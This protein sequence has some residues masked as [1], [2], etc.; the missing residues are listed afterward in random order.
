MVQFAARQPQDLLGGG[1]HGPGLWQSFNREGVEQVLAGRMWPMIAEPGRRQAVGD[2]GRCSRMAGGARCVRILAGIDQRPGLNSGNRVCA[3]FAESVQQFMGSSVRAALSA[4]LPYFLRP[5]RLPAGTGCVNRGWRWG[6]AGHGRTM[7]WH[8]RDCVMPDPLF[9]LSMAHKRLPRAA[10]P[11][12]RPL[13]LSRAGST[14]SC[15]RP[16]HRRRR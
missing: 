11:P 10:S 12:A 1:C 3:L 9:S 14:R 7:L 8:D 4:R 5:M 6:K 13:S 2:A 16:D 15:S